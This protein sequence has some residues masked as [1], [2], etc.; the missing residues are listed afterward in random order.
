M[1]ATSPKLAYLSHHA[2]RQSRARIVEQ[3]FEGPWGTK[4]SDPVNVHVRFVI[5]V[6]VIFPTFHPEKMV[7]TNRNTVFFVCYFF[8]GV[9]LK[10]PQGVIHGAQ[11]PRFSKFQ[12][13]VIA[14][15]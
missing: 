12:K 10:L 9:F 5:F 8:Q 13:N 11:I 3:R 14:S 15:L 6:L 4:N 1:Y 7:E 2:R